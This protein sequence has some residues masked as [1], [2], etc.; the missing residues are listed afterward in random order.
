MEHTFEVNPDGDTAEQLVADYRNVG[1]AAIR[2]QEELRK[3][4]ASG[5]HIRNY[6]NDE[7]GMAKH[8]QARADIFAVLGQAL[9]IQEWAQEGAVR[10]H[11]Q[12]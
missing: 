2:L 6:Q 5:G 7:N 10:A 4:M 3:L 12:S 1:I 8:R 9:A 11:G